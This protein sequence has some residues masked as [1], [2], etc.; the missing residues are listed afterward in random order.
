MADDEGKSTSDETEEDDTLMKMLMHLEDLMMDP[1]V[2]FDDEEEEEWNTSN[3]KEGDSLR[4][5]IRQ[6]E[7][8]A[9]E[10]FCGMLVSSSASS[11]GESKCDDVSGRHDSAVAGSPEFSLEHTELHRQF[12]TLVEGHVER[13]LQKQGSSAHALVEQIRRAEERGSSGGNAWAVDASREIVTLL[14][15]VDDFELW[16][17]NMLQKARNQ[18]VLAAA[19]HK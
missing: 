4:E 11:R 3:S 14:K 10:S 13:F 18:R 8:R 5:E 1:V 7:E 6:F 9:A 15:E 17:N 12:C 2:L 19:S 16:A